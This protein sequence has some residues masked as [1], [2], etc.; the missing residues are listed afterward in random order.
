MK[1]SFPAAVFLACSLA[2][3]VSCATYSQTD[4]YVG[5]QFL[6][7]FDFQSISDPSHGRVSVLLPNSVDLVLTSPSLSRNYVDKA[8]AQSLGLVSSTNNSF[9]L[10]A[11]HTT[12]L[13]AN[14][15]GRNSFRIQSNNQY[16]THVAV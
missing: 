6:N 12:T 4:S 14:G 5:S 2:S 13:S 16:T 11:D 10:R 3:R 7:G 8:T 9:V 15:P 1:L